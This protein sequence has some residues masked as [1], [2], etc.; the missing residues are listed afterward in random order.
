MADVEQITE[1]ARGSRLPRTTTRPF[2]M[3]DELDRPQGLFE[4]PAVARPP[5]IYAPP[6]A[7]RRGG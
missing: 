1:S 2:A 3:V 6:T 5:V 7:R 4:E